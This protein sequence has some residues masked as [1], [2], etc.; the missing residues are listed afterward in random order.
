MTERSKVGALIERISLQVSSGALHPGERLPSIRRAASTLGVA[1]NT[2]AEAYARLTSLGVVESLPG[3]GYRVVSRA[4][5]PASNPAK[6]TLTEAVDRMSLMREQTER[7]YD[8]RPGDARVPSQWFQDLDLSFRSSWVHEDRTDGP[9]VHRFTQWGYRPLRERLALSLSDR[10]ISVTPDQVLLTNGANHALDLI[11]RH[12]VQPGDRVLVDD[13]GY[14]PIFGKLKL[15][16]AELVGVARTVTGPDVDAL[17][18]AAALRPK[19]FF[20]QSLAHNPTGGN[21]SPGTA[22]AVLRLAEQYDFRVVESD[23]V[24]DII[25]ATAPRLAAL[26][27][28]KRVIYVGTFSKTLNFSLRVGSLA[29]APDDA[30]ALADLKLV[31]ITGTSELA[32]RLVSELV[33]SG[34]YLRH[35]RRLRNRLEVA[36]TEAR[37]AYAQFGITLPESSGLY[38]W[39]PLPEPVDELEVV[40]Q[41]AAA[42]IF[43]AAGSVFAANSDTRRPATRVNVAYACDPRFLTFLRRHVF[44]NGSAAP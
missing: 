26:D 17:A 28:L 30:A 21:L 18:A 23:P 22:Y 12:F 5:K 1:K 20:T 33:S 7:Q 4:A 43:M 3:S 38:H 13:P 36:H 6:K 39:V 19:L 29:A 25:P 10:Q 27:Q 8:V 14:Y 16:G 35:L 2:V 42:G 41:A 32:E 34:R 24:A 44:V 11:I 40:R 37:S 15:A 9:D 31:T